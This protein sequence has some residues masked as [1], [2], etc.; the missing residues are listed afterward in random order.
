LFVNIWAPHPPLAVPEPYASLFDPERLELPPNVGV[1]AANEPWNRRKGVPAQLAEGVTL[2]QWRKTW[3]AHL[4][5]TRLADDCIGRLLDALK[6]TGAY[7]RTIIL[8]MSDHGD[9]L[10]QHGMYQK[11]EMYEQAIRVPMLV[12]LPS[13]G[14]GRRVIEQPV[15]HLDIVPTLLDVLDLTAPPQQLDGISL[16]PC[17]E[18]GSPLPERYVFSQYSGNPGIG[19]IR[20]AVIGSRYKYIYDPDAEAELYDL[21]QDPLEMTNVAAE[22]AMQHVLRDMHDAL[23]RWG[24][25]RSDWVR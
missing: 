24:A 5:L 17:L 10:G 21:Q 15:S 23:L 1:P 22:P 14:S 9:H 3:A 11:M 16:A 25:D 18:Q 12:K 6:S 7:E 2:E 13:P 19:D 4:G 8:F 20:R